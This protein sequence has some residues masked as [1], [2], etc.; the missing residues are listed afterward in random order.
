MPMKETVRSLRAYFILSGLSSLFFSGS[1]LRAGLQGP[2]TNTT[3][4]EVVGIGFSLGF[5]YIGFSLASLLKSSAKH[6]V[7][8]LYASTG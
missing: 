5:L 7:A 4:V 6:I 8:L 3:V 1:A 2:V